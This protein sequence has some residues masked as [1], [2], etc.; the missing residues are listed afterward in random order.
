MHSAM[1]QK[2]DQLALR[3]CLVMLWYVFDLHWPTWILSLLLWLQVAWYR[4]LQNHPFQ[5][6]K[7]TLGGVVYITFF[8]GSHSL[9]FENTHAQ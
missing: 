7:A 3:A 2:H 5:S 9:L 6:R 1:F 8:D 4:L